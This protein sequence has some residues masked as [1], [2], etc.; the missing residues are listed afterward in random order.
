MHE[1]SFQAL[2]TVWSVTVD[3]ESVTPTHEQE[4][5]KFLNDFEERFSR[6]LPNSEVNRFREARPGHY[7][8]S[9][10]FFVLLQRAEELRRLTGGVYDPAV[11]GLLERAGYGLPSADTPY[12]G[13]PGDFVLPHWSLGKT[14]I[15]LDGPACFDLGGMGKGYAIDRVAE[16]LAGRGYRHY[17]V[18]GGGD[19]FGTTKA[20]GS[21]WRV[22]IEY[23]G[24][25]DMAAGTLELKEQGLA[26]SDIFRRRFGRWHHVVNP[27]TKTV[28]EHCVGAAAVAPT[29]WA[30]DCMTSGLLLG[31]P[32]WWGE[33]TRA[34][35]AS[36]L[37]FFPEG[38]VE[39]SRDWPG[40][41]FT[42]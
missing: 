31:A 27:Q 39:R 15:I 6:F 4:V 28:Q 9:Q 32:S 42:A 37:A 14:E 10:E 18:E 12:Q 35:Q 40:E 19:M 22:A 21:P 13:E 17:L 30:A 23:P 33:L 5:R 41:L 7:P 36:F 2:G 11:G 1:F 3:G 16:L 24:K 26:V 38:R 25:T 20:D 34:Y 8:I 29:A